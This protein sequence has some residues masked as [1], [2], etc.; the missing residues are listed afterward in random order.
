[1]F[2]F[3]WLSEEQNLKSELVFPFLKFELVSLPLVFLLLLIFCLYCV[4]GDYAKRPYK[5]RPHDQITRIFGEVGDRRRWGLSL[6]SL[7]LNMPLLISF[8]TT[9]LGWFVFKNG[10]CKSSYSWLL[11]SSEEG[12]GGGG[13]SLSQGRSRLG[14]SCD[15]VLKLEMH[16]RLAGV[17]KCHM[18]LVV[19]EIGP[20]LTWQESA[21]GY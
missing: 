13:L 20:A 8:W 6:L 10:E 16:W 9:S 7:L 14:R 3:S 17:I 12:I 19:M 11:Q 18:W 1:M 2:C 4:E 15:G 5:S 21:F